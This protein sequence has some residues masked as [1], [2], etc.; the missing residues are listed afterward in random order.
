MG[1]LSFL[2]GS[3]PATVTRS[4]QGGSIASA[5]DNLS[6][7][8][9]ATS[10]GTRVSQL[11][12]MQIA[13][14]RRAVS[15]RAMDVA[16]CPP[17]VFKIAKNGKKVPQF[18]HPV[19]ARFVRPNPWQSWF[20]FIEQL[21]L[22]FLLRGNAYFVRLTDNRGACW[23]WLPINPD[24]VTVFESPG[25]LIFYNVSRVGLWLQAQL[26][27]EDT[28]VPA[29]SMFHLRDMSF[30]TLTG[31]QRIVLGRST[32]GLTL[33][34]EEQAAAWARN[35]ARPGGLLT[36]DKKLSPEAAARLK[37]RWTS[38][39]SGLSN[40]GNTAVLEDGVKWT[41]MELKATDTQFMQGRQF[42]IKEIARMFDVPLY[43]LMESE[44]KGGGSIVEQQA[45]YVQTT[46]MGDLT[47][48]ERRFEHEFGLDEEGLVVKF[49]ESELLRADIMTQRNV[50][51]LGVLS[52]MLT[53]NE[54]R[55]EINYGPSDDPRADKLLFPT[56]LAPNGSAVDGTAPGNGGRPAGTELP[57]DNE[58]GVKGLA[59]PIVKTAE[60]I[61]ADADGPD[62]DQ[63]TDDELRELFHS[64]LLDDAIDDDASGRAVLVAFPREV[65]KAFDSSKHPRGSNGRFGNGGAAKTVGEA[66]MQAHGVQGHDKIVV[67]AAKVRKYKGHDTVESYVAGHKNGRAYALRQ[68]A[69]D[70]GAGKIGFKPGEAPAAKTKADGQAYTVPDRSKL[71]PAVGPLHDSDYLVTLNGSKKYPPGITVGDFVA[72][73]PKGGAAARRMIAVDQQ[74]GRLQVERPAETKPLAP[75]QNPEDTAPS[76]A[77][78][79]DVKADTAGIAFGRDVSDSFRHD[80]AAGWGKVPDG[81]KDR[82]RGAGVVF[83]A[84]KRLLDTFPEFDGVR[85]RGWPEGKTWANVEGVFS[86]SSGRS[87]TICVA[88]TRVDA[89]TNAITTSTRASSV[90][91]H[92]V[93]HGLDHALGH[94]SESPY[95]RKLY[96]ADVAEYKS[97]SNTGRSKNDDYDY[98]LQSGSAGPSEMF[99]E[100]FSLSV[101]S[102]A[103]NWQSSRLLKDFPRCATYM[104]SLVSNLT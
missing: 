10:A 51:R 67:H 99:A 43:K 66:H 16:R 80:V 58:A 3:V 62:A 49:D 18:Q 100:Q 54:G 94:A 82:L 26:E 23:A 19:M 42:S 89:F 9:V 33:A 90:V 92:E 97:V 55:L 17:G 61:D 6:L 72:N 35:G 76:A 64:D 73:H 39:M 4:Y 27:G 56:N 38:L 44:G 45:E 47:R 15:L 11:T 87:P 81:V 24:L 21:H 91:T 83:A 63:V 53:P 57:G 75:R 85:P 48:W 101:G 68:L 93:G 40:S 34:Q 25:G 70:H 84:P 1:L 69:A 71:T 32:M 31:L 60:T 59:P 79:A 65:A 88:E 95:Y 86:P 28:M 78:R 8:S 103:N 52:G 98:F 13:A 77:A 46:V 102:K 36:S 20:E 29:E 104:Q 14:V 30:N 41:P 5:T 7:G 96:D 22:G 37:T 2:R 12:V 74:Q 50:A